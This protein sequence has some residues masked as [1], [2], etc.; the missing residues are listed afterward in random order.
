MQ[1]ERDSFEIKFDELRQ[2][3]QDCQKDKN[4]S[5]CMECEKIFDCEL[6]RDFVDATYNSMSKGSSGD[7]DF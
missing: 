3:L 1:Q 6:R 5:S 2:K 7:F 4:L